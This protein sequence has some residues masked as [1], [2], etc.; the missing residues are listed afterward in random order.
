MAASQRG[1]REGLLLAPS[2][3]LLAYLAGAYAF[4][5]QAGLGLLVPLRAHEVGVPLALIGVIVGLGGLVPALLSVP[6][7]VLIDR[8][9]AR[10]AYMLGSACMAVVGGLFMIAPNAWSLLLLQAGAGFSRTLAWVAIQTYVSSLG[11]SEQQPGVA[12]RFSFF[13]NAGMFGAPLL[14]GAVAQAAGYALA[15]SVIAVSS[16][17]FV[18]LG[19]RLPDLQR[20]PRPAGEQ[21][22]AVGFSAATGML[23]NPGMQVVLLLTF[24]RLWIAIGW[25]AF[26]P[27]ILASKGFP[28][29]LIGTVVAS[30]SAVAALTT[31]SAGTLAR[32]ARKELLAAGALALAGLGALLSPHFTTMPIVFIPPLF[33][34]IGGGI[35]L[36]M[37]LAIVRD[38]VPA[39]QRGLALGVRMMA[40]QT[41]VIAVPIIVGWF[42]PV[43][44]ITLGFAIIGLGAWVFQGGAVWATLRRGRTGRIEAASEPPDTRRGDGGDAGQADGSEAGSAKVTR[45]RQATPRPPD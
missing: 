4:G 29:A 9:G 41:A 17:V 21:R 14:A 7:G 3:M 28:P 35:S 5:T 19:S 40:N 10:R 25:N 15:F 33:L 2:R 36:P 30:N 23:K 18:A 44:G 1:A 32:W 8:M 34:G 38:S 11:T 12:G 37:L 42:I 45:D 43:V 27:L 22:T 16:A 26:F 20:S 31:L 13:S 6:L 39:H 24:S